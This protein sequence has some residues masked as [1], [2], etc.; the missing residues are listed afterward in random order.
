MNRHRYDPE[1]ASALL[2]L[3]RS[4]TAELRE[5]SETIDA[6]ERELSTLGMSRRTRERRGDLEG[7]LSVQR[8]ELRVAH[9]ELERLGCQLDADH[10]LRVL[11]P[12]V[13]GDLDHGFAWSPLDERLLNLQLTSS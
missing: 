3:L 4:I 11:I 10:P 7:A 5:R 6:L 8:R 2:P 1:R 9:R 13:D 12:G